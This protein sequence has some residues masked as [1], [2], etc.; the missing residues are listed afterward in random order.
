MDATDDRGGAGPIH[1]PVPRPVDRV[2]EA[3]RQKAREELVR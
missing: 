1:P 2:S 3:E